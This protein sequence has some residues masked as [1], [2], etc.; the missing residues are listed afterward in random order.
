MCTCRP[1]Y[2]LFSRPGRGPALPGRAGPLRRVAASRWPRLGRL[3]RSRSALAFF[4]RN[5]TLGR[6]VAFYPGPAGAT[7]SR[8]AARR[9]G[10]DRGGEPAA[11]PTSP[12]RRG[13]AGARRRTAATAQCHLVPIDACYELVGQLRRCGAASTAA[14]RRTTAIDA[15]FADG[16]SARSPAGWA[17]RDR[18]TAFTV[19]RR[20]RR[21][22]RGRPAA[23]R[24]AA[25]RGVH[26][27]DACTRSRCAARSA[28]SRSA[29][30]YDDGDGAGLRGPVRRARP[31]GRHAAAV[32]LDAVQHHGAGLHRAAPRST[33]RCRAPTTSRSPASHVPARAG[34]GD[35]PL[36]AA[37][38]RHRVHPRRAPGSASSRCRGTARRPTGCRSRSGST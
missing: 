1:C 19:A 16:A 13:A 6:M 32:P 21:A 31:L 3:C 37:V 36:D 5:S 18:A 20:R 12:R 22:V 25:D 8:A 15:F 24:A 9:L 34:D 10:P 7:E 38:L 17:R 26:R 27:P 23:D 14:R 28:S 11:R 35:V 30:R 2:L 33:C 4:F 29:R